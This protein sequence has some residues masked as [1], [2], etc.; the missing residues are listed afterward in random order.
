MARQREYYGVRGLI[1]SAFRKEA[2][3]GTVAVAFGYLGLIL[4]ATDLF[5]RL[6]SANLDGLRFYLWVSYTTVALLFVGW[7]TLSTKLRVDLAD[8]R[9]Q[10]SVRD[11]GLHVQHQMVEVVRA[12]VGL[13]ESG[14]PIVYQEQ[15]L[16]IGELLK[17]YLRKRLPSQ[18][19]AVTIKVVDKREDGDR[20]KAIFRDGAQDP[21][22]RLPGNDISLSASC[23]FSRFKSEPNE[24]QKSVLI[25][26]V[27]RLEDERDRDFRARAEK[28]GFQSVIGFPLR[29]PVGLT[30]GT[31]FG[32][33]KCA[34][35]FGFLS[36]DSPLVA[37]FDELFSSP[38]SGPDE[39]NYGS[40]RTALADMDL[41]YGI[42]DAVATL[43]MLSREP[44]IT[45]GEGASHG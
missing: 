43:V 38:E 16:R 3:P 30:E 44:D 23:I 8:A 32:V 7:A 15:L 21:T 42:A 20:L 17:T 14:K 26:D 12:C 1:A 41:F 24:P 29:N 40:D 13:K 10:V 5:S 27:G 11:E 39:R 2:L 28:A 36:I 6:F 18:E 4:T 45:H 37:A 22:R 33:L 31:D 19:F 35:I 34:S 25:R 9:R